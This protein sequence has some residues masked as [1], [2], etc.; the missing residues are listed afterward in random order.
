MRSRSLL[1]GAGVVALGLAIGVVFARS[2]RLPRLSFEVTWPDRAGQY[3]P[4]LSWADEELM[5]V[6]IGSS[7][8]GWSTLEWV[9]GAVD[10]I[11]VE[12]GHKAAER[13]LGF[14]TI[15][16]SRDWVV[17]AG[18]E[19]LR[20]IGEFD[21][22]AAGYGWMNAAVARYVWD[23]FPGDAATP[24]LLLLHRRLRVPIQTEGARGFGIEDE[25]L[26]Q[27]VVGVSEIR[28]WLDGGV[29]IRS[30]IGTS[31]SS[32]PDRRIGGSVVAGGPLR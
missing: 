14:S 2:D 29:P 27:R 7:T 16:V 21:Q 3:R 11:K 17:E 25:T 28:D 26:I 24:Q 9:P 8:C 4:A 19:H 23:D 13:G 6:Y 5:L 10:S 12:L 22:V 18:I 15:G 20:W 1:H 32:E 31:G 30:S